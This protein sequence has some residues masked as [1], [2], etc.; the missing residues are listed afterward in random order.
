MTNGKKGRP[1]SPGGLLV[2]VDVGNT[3][4]VFGVYRGDELVESFRLSTDAERTADEYGSLLLPL[5]SRAGVDPTSAEAV[6]ISSVVPPLQF[7]LD[8]L[9]RHY[10]GKRPLFIEPGVKT[11]MPIRYDNPAEVGAD[12]IVNAV[13]ARELYGAPVV[14]VD[15][16][17]ATT[18][19]LVNAAGEYA[20]GI[21][22]PGIT[23]S[24]EALFA[25]A[26]R[27]YR[28]DIK[29]PTELV[30]KNTATAMQ[31]GIYYGYVGLVDGILE[32]LVAEMPGLKT[33]VAT[34]GQADLIATGS[35]YIQRVDPMLTLVG[36]K[37]IYE[38]N[39]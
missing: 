39:R 23:I 14:V 6:V 2:L 1:R 5:F 3:N 33:V 4:T 25:H 30:G 36:L 31:A 11:G 22:C 28:V 16:G 7:T 17:T 37:L 15:F 38:R 26:S 12:R 8:Q 9:S 10:F 34:G 27:L 18:F 24:A 29:K 21:I 20:G 35:R 13:A 19:D 32:R